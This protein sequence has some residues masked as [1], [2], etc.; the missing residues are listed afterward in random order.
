MC[1]TNSTTASKYNLP[2]KHLYFNYVSYLN[3]IVKIKFE[4]VDEAIRA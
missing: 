3:V 1:I 2:I 4:V